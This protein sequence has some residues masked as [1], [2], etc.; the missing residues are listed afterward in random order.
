ML[1]E[2]DEIARLIKELAVAIVYRR[3]D[4]TASIARKSGDL[5][6]ERVG[7]YNL[8][9]RDEAQVARLTEIQN[10]LAALIQRKV[11]IER[12]ATAAREGLEGKTLAY[13]QQVD[14]AALS[15]PS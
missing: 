2:K 14:V 3:E 10:E 6:T 5:E 12:Y 13:L 7:L 15:W 9:E 8:P 11:A 4:L 1:V